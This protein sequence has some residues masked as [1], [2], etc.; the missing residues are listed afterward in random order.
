MCGD[1]AQTELGAGALHYS[2]SH[3]EVSV[4]LY[5]SVA[6]A[7]RAIKHH[8]VAFY[9]VFQ[10]NYQFTPALFVSLQLH[11]SVGDCHRLPGGAKHMGAFQETR[12]SGIQLHLGDWETV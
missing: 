12:V 8:S 10:P 6:S 2:V 3:H 1:P 9:L 7:P 11:V 4:S 5:C